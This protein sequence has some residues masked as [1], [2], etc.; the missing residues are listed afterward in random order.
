M[1]NRAYG[2][3]IRTLNL[4]RPRLPE[5]T[6]GN[7][8]NLIRP[9]QLPRLPYRGIHAAYMHAIGAGYLCNIRKIINDKN[10]FLFLRERLKL[11]RLFK[12]AN[13]GGILIPQLNDINALVL[14]QPENL[15]LAG[16]SAG[17]T[18]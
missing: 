8:D 17:L 9:E 5:A 10:D 4:S 2:N 13:L 1:K 7:A 14:Y 3:V 18:V 6:A 15:F 11:Q 12:D 16:T